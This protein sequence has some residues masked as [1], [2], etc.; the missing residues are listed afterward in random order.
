MS[1]TILALTPSGLASPA[2]TPTVL[3][4]VGLRAVHPVRALG[5]EAYASASWYG[6]GL[7]GNHLACGGTLSP[8]DFH[9]AHRTL[10]CGTRLI[11]CYR[12]RCAATWVGDRGPYVGGRTFDLGPG[13]ARSLGFD[14][15]HT[16][17]YTIPRR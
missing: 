15:V 12:S 14:G 4:G 5:V 7:Y 1:A 10:P 11:I 6:P 16:V 8:G 9:V 2:S 3:A 17:R 13:L